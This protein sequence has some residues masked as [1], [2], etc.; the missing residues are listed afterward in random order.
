VN[1]EK[2]NPHELCCQPEQQ[3]T[4]CDGTEKPTARFSEVDVGTMVDWLSTART[5]YWHD[6][7]DARLMVILPP[8]P[9]GTDGNWKHVGENPKRD[10]TSRHLRFGV[11]F[12]LSLFRLTIHFREAYNICLC[13]VPFQYRD[14]TPCITSA[15][16]IVGKLCRPPYDSTQP[17]LP[18]Y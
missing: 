5:N 10:V 14:D 7:V 8:H 9:H 4:N 17:G 16:T 3:L 18:R 1:V 6:I 2:S 12:L 15:G 11:T 13:G